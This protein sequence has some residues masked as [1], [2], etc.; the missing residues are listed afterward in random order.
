MLN[1]V[2]EKLSDLLHARAN[3]YQVNKLKDVRTIADEQKG[4]VA[5]ASGA[6]PPRSTPDL[7]TRPSS[8]PA[9]E[10]LTST[11]A[12]GLLPTPMEAVMVR[13]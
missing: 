7:A 8:S 3:L 10:V 12:G 13:M 4:K 11:L 6:P 2:S 5:S 1:A 9:E